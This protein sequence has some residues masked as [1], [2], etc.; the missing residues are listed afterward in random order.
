MFSDHQNSTASME[1]WKV[2][3]EHCTF[4][5]SAEDEPAVLEE[6]QSGLIKNLT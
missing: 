6:K 1:R 4:G 3:L 2:L 5:N